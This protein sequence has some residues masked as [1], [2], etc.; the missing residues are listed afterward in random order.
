MTWEKN[1]A[2]ASL[3]QLLANN[4]YFR[5]R[6]VPPLSITSSVI[7]QFYSHPTSLMVAILE[8]RVCQKKWHPCQ[9]CH[10]NM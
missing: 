2:T 10:V 5:L 8:Y 6:A 4:N 7:D 9:L 1:L 3:L